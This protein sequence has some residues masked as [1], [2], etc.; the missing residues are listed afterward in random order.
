MSNSRKRMFFA[1]GGVLG[2]LVL[3]GLVVLLVLGVHA[4]RQVQILVSNA[5]GME[6]SVTGGLSF[7]FFPRFHVAM[8]NVQLRNGGSQLATAAQANLGIELLPLLYGEVRMDSIELQHVRAMIERQR[9][10]KFNF[11]TPS[12]PSGTIQFAD[13]TKVS[14]ADV[15]VLY[16]DRQSGK[17][18]EAD[19]CHLDVSHLRRS[20]QERALA[21]GR[22]S[23]TAGAACETI[24]TTDLVVSDVQL[25]IDGK[26]GVFDLNPV[27]M[28]VFGGLGS[29]SIRADFS[30]AVPDYRV[31]YSLSKFRLAQSFRTLSSRNVGDGP[32][33]F[34]ANLSMQGV[35][36]D[37][38]V[39]SATGE[40]SLSG[41]DLT[42]AIGDIDKELARYE[43]SQNF[44][45]VDVG[46]L[47]F[48]GPLGLAVTKGFNFASVFQSSGGSSQIRTL[49][50]DWHIERGVAQ[51]KDVAMATRENRI[52]LKGGLDFV[53]ERFKEVTVAVIDAQGC[54]TAQEKIRGPFDRP[55]VEKPSVATSL[56]GPAR[57]LLKQAK[58][59]FGEKCDVFYAGSVAP[60]R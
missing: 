12:N 28:H 47:F 51:A 58:R 44:N 57:M 5:L 37:E 50:S 24:G 60:P 40:A 13:A 48:A 19:A 52:A 31:H 20:E 29:G 38:L 22:L 6:V 14:L 11:E 2:V 42:L 3:V 18:F 36:K 25:S 33:D 54:A 43:S 4:K 35:T 45:L 7:G 55:E 8:E 49:V 39:R 26:E 1:I 27:T 16:T 10:G 15:T 23:F 53:N 9:N 34:T 41:H 30:A 17:G 46:A 56:A 59:F 32:M 21:L